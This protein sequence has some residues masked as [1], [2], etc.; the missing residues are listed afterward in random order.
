[1]TDRLSRRKLLSLAGAGAAAVS[2]PAVW[3]RARD[4]A[5]DADRV[6][7]FFV[8]DTHFL[9]DKDNP[10]RLDER[11]AT[12]NRRLIDVLN[13]LPGTAI[14]ADAA[15]G[16]GGGVVAAPR[17]VIH[18]GDLIDTGDKTGPA[19]AAMQRTDWKACTDAF[20]LDGTDGR[21]RYPVYEIHG[22]HDGPRGT[23]LVI[24]GIIDRNKRRPGLAGTSPNG[25]HYSWDWG[26][27][28]FVNL[29][30]VVGAV[31]EVTRRRRYNPL[32]SLDFLRRDLQEH[33]G[34]S[35][36]PVVL[37]H[38]V[39]V[40]RYTTPCD[41]AAP[42]A[43]KEWDPCDVAAY[44]QLAREYNV[45]AV[46]YGHTHARAVFKWDGRSTKS[47]AG[48]DV[49]NV[50]ESSHFLTNAHGLFYF[51]LTDRRMTVR[52][53]ATKDNWQTAAWSAAWTYPIKAPARV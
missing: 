28:H 50:D 27:V 3:A 6:C 23:G 18:G 47:A 4:A 51:E 22:N 40:A 29:G 13:R 35:G 38:H 30:I 48:L 24:D 14:P 31:P 10:D 21:L 43:N 52:E 41:P 34:R 33:V 39:D 16:A 11:S 20:G 53:Y 49:F 44:Y 17:G 25:L 45:V 37:T 8:S 46:L 9:A 26:P 15:G 7:F 1:M 5:A 19:A 2:I 42:F 32:A 12:A 36:R